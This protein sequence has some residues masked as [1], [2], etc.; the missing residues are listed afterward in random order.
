MKLDKII[1]SQNAYYSNES[2]D[3]INSNISV[4]NLLREEGI[5]DININEDAL[6]SY[7]LDYYESQYNNGNFS[8]F[9]W[10]TGWLP[11]LNTIIEQGLKKINAN[12]HLQLF[13][14]QSEK[15]N[16]LN[17]ETLQ[18]FLDGQYFGDN[19]IRDQLKNDTFFDL[20]ESIRDLNSKW[21]KK[22][23][24]LNV[25]AIDDM[26]LELERFIGRKIAR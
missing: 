24:K 14:Q 19:A 10:N 15:V 13:T 18:T 23:P 9:V 4:I 11:N 5:E 1:V 26:F 21:L 12:K 7:Y 6:T 8:Q 17:K 20:D 3:I 16:N 2:Y 25:L 22:H